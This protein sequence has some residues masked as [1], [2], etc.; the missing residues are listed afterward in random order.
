MEPD[1][2]SSQRHEDRANHAG[3]GAPVVVAR[4]CPRCGRS[5]EEKESEPWTR[6]AAA[7]LVA[8]FLLLLVS[9]TVWAATHI[10]ADIRL[11]M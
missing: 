9:G 6:A 4:S 11:A 2:D 8:C 1:P 3:E 5:L 7:I 10:W